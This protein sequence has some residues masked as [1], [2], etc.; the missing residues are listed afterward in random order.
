M[1]DLELHLTGSLHPH[2]LINA[3]PPAEDCELHLALEIPDALFP[4]PDE[5]VDLWGKSNSS[6]AAADK[7]YAWAVF[8]RDIDIE[9]PVLASAA[10]VR[11][12]LWTRNNEVDIPLHARYLPPSSEGWHNVTVFGEGGGSVRRG[13]ACGSA[14]EKR[15]GMC[16]PM[17]VI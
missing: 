16:I 4:D 7:P 8:P 10:L 6:G 12:S 13:W 9:R 2:L 5:L 15:A 11:V 14:Q 3:H 1:T 17:V